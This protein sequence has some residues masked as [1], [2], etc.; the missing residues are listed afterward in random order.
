M[1]WDI[2]VLRTPA[3][4]SLGVKQFQFPLPTNFLLFFPGIAPESYIHMIGV[5][6]PL[7]IYLLGADFKVVGSGILHLG[8]VAPVPQGAEYLIETSWQAAVLTDFG[9]LAQYL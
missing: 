6:E 8:E 4:Q 1:A 7:H 2:K 9:F 5:K 3:E